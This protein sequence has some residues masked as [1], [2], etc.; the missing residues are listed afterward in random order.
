M[1][2]MKRKRE[3]AENLASLGTQGEGDF[4]DGPNA[5]MYTG[6]SGTMG[7]Q[8]SG[9]Q[10]GRKTSG[11]GRG[12]REEGGGQNEEFFNSEFL[13][14]FYKVPS[15]SQADMAE[16]IGEVQKGTGIDMSP[17]MLVEALDNF[18]ISQGKA[19]KIISQAIRNKY[20]MT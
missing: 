1:N 16:I 2:M 15:L 13:N 20:R 12:S 7:G 5:D 14:E 9:G 11:G 17:R 18:I 10:R 4:V 6:F 19:K 8:E 3:P